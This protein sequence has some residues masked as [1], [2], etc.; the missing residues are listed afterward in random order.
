MIQHIN[1]LTNSVI[2]G[3][4]IT[5]ESALEIINISNT[6][7]DSLEAL[8]NGANEIRK[9]FIGNKADLCTIKNVKSGKC[10]EDCTFCAQSSH[11]T[12]SVEEYDILPYSEILASAQEVEAFG[13]HRFSLVS[14]G[15][16][17]TDD[18]VTVLC[19]IYKKLKKDTSLKLCASHGLLSY[20][21]GLRL[22]EAGVEKYHHNLEA[23]ENYYNTVCQ[24]HSFQDRVDTIVNATKAGLEVCSGGIFGIGESSVNRVEMA[25]S[26]KDLNIT[27]IPINILTPIKGTPLE[28]S[29]ALE[30]FEILKTIALYKF[31]NPTAHIRYAGGRMSLGE[32]Q[33]I[34]FNAG[35][36]AALVGNYLTTSGSNMDNDKKMLVNAGFTY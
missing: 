31:I 2:N 11:F 4:D 14:S 17:P 33:E 19:D 29:K 34:G 3:N 9:K 6:D 1:D 13:G 22:K 10:S 12:T 7:S 35:V 24:T 18:E 30:P 32:Y 23:S 36:S 21:Q 26:L 16:G 20:E 25:F 15:R 5:L 27:S 8:F 28:S